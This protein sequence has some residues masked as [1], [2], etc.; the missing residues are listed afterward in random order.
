MEHTRKYNDVVR[1]VFKAVAVAM[2]AAA[3][4]LGTLGA[5]TPVTLI[6]LLSIGLFC[7][8]ITSMQR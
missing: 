2:S 4:V 6:E 1:T 5:A 3:V 7:L 8:A